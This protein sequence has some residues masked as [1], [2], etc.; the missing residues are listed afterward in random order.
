LHETNEHNRRQADRTA[1]LWSNRLQECSTAKRLNLIY[2][3]N[4]VVQQS[5]ARKKT[6]FLVAFEPMIGDATALAYKHASQDVQGKLKRVVEVWRER[7]IFDPRIQENIE[8]KLNEIDKAKG[9]KPNGGAV[10]GKLGGNLFGGG[11]GGNVPTELE[12]VA[13]T[14]AK[15][16]KSEASAKPDVERAD[17]E[18]TKMTDPDAPVPTAPVHAAKLSALMKTLASAQGAVEASIQARKELIVGLEKLLESNRA[19]LAD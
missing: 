13:A 10:S 9:I 19:K 17:A 14:Q 8:G 15:L 1:Q 7:K 12:A 6:E 2:L 5:R 3:A 4:E 16:S 11:S 18:Y